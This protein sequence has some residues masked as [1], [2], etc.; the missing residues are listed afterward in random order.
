MALSRALLVLSIALA[1]TCMQPTAAQERTIPAEAKRGYL[2]HVQEALVSVDG[3]SARLAPGATIRDQRNLIIVPTA[4][5]SEGA[6]ADY[7]EDRDRQIFRVW[8]LTPEERAR[9]RPSASRRVP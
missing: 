4:L 8:L 5:P 1:Y 6:W 9:K 2:K 3:T 7:L